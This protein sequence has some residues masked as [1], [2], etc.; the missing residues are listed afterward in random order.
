[1]TKGGRYRLHSQSV[2]A[3]AQKLIANVDT[4]RALR[5]HEQI[6]GSLT[7]R[8]PHHPRPYQTATWKD[9]AIRVGFG[10]IHLPNGR[11]QPELV[12]PL[13][14]HLHN[15]TIRK[16]ELLW[17][18]DHYQLALT[19]EQPP[20]PQLRQQGQTAG[21]DLGEINAAA[22]CTER[23]QA[24]VINGRLLRHHKQL[25]NKRHAAYQERLARCRK[26]SR[27]YLRLKRQKARA[28]AKLYRQQR[29]HLH[30]ASRKLV[31]FA[32]AQ[33]VSHLAIGDV[34]GWR[35][36]RCARQPEDQPVAAW[37]IREVH[38]VQGPTA[39]HRC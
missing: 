29:N 37:P 23:G 7:A 16:A 13:P 14:E 3:L 17:R 26:G 2:Q 6:A 28:S 18:A 15:A 19:V 36:Q 38:E 11:G 9:Q 34:R 22:A 21:V 31:D 8:Y 25:R 39:G 10:R 20:D 12:L 1:M 33:D 35:G 27:R 5:A 30:Q 32:V 4:A 24:L